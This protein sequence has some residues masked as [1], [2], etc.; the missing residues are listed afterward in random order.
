MKVSDNAAYL[1]TSTDVPFCNLALERLKDE[2]LLTEAAERD[3]ERNN[4]V[5]FKQLVIN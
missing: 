1:V 3:G 4:L 5:H 2:D